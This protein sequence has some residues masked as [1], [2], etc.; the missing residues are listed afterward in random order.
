MNKINLIPT[1]AD[2]TYS[3]NFINF[4]ITGAR[5]I[6]K[7]EEGL[8]HALSL[9]D[10][11]IKLSDNGNL[12]I[13]LGYENFTEAVK[14]ETEELFKKKF[15][16]EQGYYLVKKS[17]EIVIAAYEE[18]GAMYAF[19]T[20]KQLFFENKLPES[21]EIKDSPDFRIRANKWLLWT[22]AGMW[23]YDRG[24]GV[25]KYKDR[26]KRKLDMCLEYKINEIVFD[27][28]DFKS[29]RFPGY[30][31]IMKTL[32]REARKRKV[33]L[34]SSGYGMGYGLSGRGDNAFTGEVHMNRKSYPDGEI[35]KCIGTF[36][37]AMEIDTMPGREYGT[38][39]SN[40]ALMANKLKE[41]TDYT[42]NVEPGAIYIHNMDA[43]DIHEPLWEARCDECRKRWPNDCLWAEDGAAG[44][45]AYYI[46]N[47]Y[48][49]ISS[50]KSDDGKYD[51]KRDCIIYI[52]SPGYVY[53]HKRNETYEKSRKFWQKVSE[54]LPH[55]ENLYIGFRE[56]F[57][58]HDGDNRLRY[59][60]TRAGWKNCDFSSIQFCGG[61][62]FYSDK[63]FICGGLFN[64]LLKSASGIIIENGNGNQEAMQ[65]CN[66]E[67]LWNCE[68]S[69]YYNIP[70]MPDNYE[71]FEPFYI[72]YLKG[73]T[74]PE[75]IYGDEGFLQ[76]ICEKLYGK[77]AGA[78]F[79]E[80]FSIHGEDGAPPLTSPC[81][82]EI[83]TN[84][85]RVIF[86]MRWDNEELKQDEGVRFTV[87]SILAKY[88]NVDSSTKKA[89]DIAS[90]IYREKKYFPE[91]EEDVKWLFDNFTICEKFTDMLVRY[92]NCYKKVN[93]YFEFG[94]KIPEEVQPAL[95]AL[96]KEADELLSEINGMN[97]KAIDL[98][99]G[100]LA[101]RDEMADFLSYNAEIMLRSIKEDKRIPS[102]LRPLKQKT[103]W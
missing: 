89:K 61:D 63:L 1:P 94:E 76:I 71:D 33:H 40:E 77:G 36:D 73:N 66:A 54:L 9:L 52:V 75:E 28:F 46:K 30:N 91:L 43:D 81:S 29:E 93:A 34:M 37:E 47:L 84:F 35:Y 72:N 90:K 53:M 4:E 57:F 64:R 23:S 18:N 56:Q 19:M 39:L 2:Y 60:M 74:R 83:Y 21:F 25:E 102:N 103:H 82:C 50:V 87:N 92:M 97:L 26:I 11:K 12:V 88:I 44:A 85:T 59:D 13:Y 8:I 100:A 32:N 20:L 68:N 42:K 45:F 22:E 27:G 98:L 14:V 95:E 51:A 38:C 96:K 10:N 86:P 48:E 79:R 16:K 55:Y 58:N 62:G 67:Y 70:D 65:V 15:A 80:L 31:D 17:D 78:D 6:G 24:D 5:V 99:G 3:E 7:A 49:G 69:A 41:L 101:R